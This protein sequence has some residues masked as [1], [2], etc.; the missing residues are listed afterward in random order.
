MSFS[1]QSK[2]KRELRGQVEK[3]KFSTMYSVLNFKLYSYIIYALSRACK[4]TFNRSLI[5]ITSFL[6]KRDNSIITSDAIEDIEICHDL[7]I[8]ALE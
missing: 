7:I 2:D 6:S 5:K 1:E 3:F 8:G 4:V